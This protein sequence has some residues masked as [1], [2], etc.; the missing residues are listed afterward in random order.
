MVAATVPIFLV[1]ERMT[2]LWL[3]PD[4]TREIGDRGNGLV[5]Y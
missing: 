4:T 5:G 3:T 1:R 2:I